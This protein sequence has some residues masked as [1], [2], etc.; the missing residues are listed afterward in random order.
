MSETNSLNPI[1]KFFAN[2]VSWVCHPVFM[3]IIMAVALMYLSPNSF[4]GLSDKNL[5]LWKIMITANAV[6]YPLFSIF[7]LKPLGF[8]KSYYMPDSK[9]RIIPLLL[10]M[11]FYFWTSH[12][13]NN[14]SDSLV[15]LVL[16]VLLLGNFWGVIVLFIIN[17]FTKIS[18]HTAAAGGMV[19]IIIVLM[20]MSPV[21][22][23]YPFFASLIIAGIVGTARMLLGAHQRG[24]IWLG[25][26]VG[27]IVQVAAY[28]YMRK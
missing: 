19:G 8:I 11:I 1:V 22:M 17:I 7:M 18:M 23:V 16:R 3:P 20:I 2:F 4:A 27:V 24:D 13:F 5:N 10:T 12:V 15:P 21:N 6:F 14:I 9:E 26:I 28:Y 25:Y